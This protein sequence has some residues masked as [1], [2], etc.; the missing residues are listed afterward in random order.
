MW[1]AILSDPLGVI[2][3]VSRYLTNYLI[4]RE[5]LLAHCLAA[6]FLIPP[7]AE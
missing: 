7:S 6:A 1:G 4:R 5:P 3:L 2:G